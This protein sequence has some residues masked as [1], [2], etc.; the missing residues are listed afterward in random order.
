M[1]STNLFTRGAR[2]SLF[3]L[4]VLTC[5][6]LAPGSTLL[7]TSSSRQG[8]VALAATIGV[9]GGSI[10]RRAKRPPPS[11]SLPAIDTA[12]EAE[13]G[14]QPDHLPGP[15]RPADGPQEQQQQQ[16]GQPRIP[17]H[18]WL[19]RQT[20]KKNSKCPVNCTVYGTCN[21]ELG[22]CDCPRHRDG[23]NCGE[24]VKGAALQKRCTQQG[25]DDLKECLNR[26]QSC[27][28]GCNQRG[29]CVGGF[30]HCAP[31]FYGSE[32]ALS[33]GRGGDRVGRPVLLAGSGYRTREKRPWVYVYELPPRLTV[34][35]NFRRLDRALHL[36]VWQ[37]LLGSGARVA[38]GDVADYYFIPVQQRS[39]GGSGLG[40]EALD[41]VRLARPGWDRT[42]GH[43]HLVLHTG[44]WGLGEVAEDVRQTGV[45][46]TWLTY[47][48]LAVDR[49]NIYRWNL[50]FRPEK[51]VVIPVYISPGH[52]KHFGVI[53]SPLHPSAKPRPRN[54]S[55]LFFAGRICHNPKRPNPQTFPSCGDDTAEAYGAGIREKFFVSHWNRSGFHVVRSEPRYGHYMS[56]SQ[57]CLAPPGAGHGQRQIQALFMGCVPVSVADGVAEPFEPAL[58]WGQWG[59]RLAEA[60]IPRAHEI[61]DNISPQ[62]LA[63]KQSRMHCAAQHMLYSTITGAVLGEDGRYDAFETM[64]EVLRVRAAHPDA[65]QHTFRDL[66]PD[67]AAFMDCR[68]PPGFKWLNGTVER[69]T[70]RPKGGGGSGSNST[71][72]AV[73]VVG[74]SVGAAAALVGNAAAAN[75]GA[76]GSQQQQQQAQGGSGT[77]GGGGDGGAD[78]DGDGDGGGNWD[79]DGDGDG[80][81]ALSTDSNRGSNV[82][83]SAGP[84]V[85]ADAPGPGSGSSAVPVPA[86][87]AG[88]S[89]TSPGPGAGPG[90]GRVPGLCS[91]ASRD[92]RNRE[93]SCYDFLR[94][95]GYMG[96]P[97][98]AMCAKGFKT[99]LALCP[100]LWG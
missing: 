22:R 71:I 88:N 25:Y 86:A 32:C 5:I 13:A 73:S 26:N 100:R 61:L 46:M 58:D 20:A 72:K 44:D 37:R 7:T 69:R 60:D 19:R 80:A 98:G 75:P 84:G 12:A 24:L 65:P 52:F 49:P 6:I 29:Q 45:N 10:L 27:I 94:G 53:R 70:Q 51:D 35:C 63:E 56:R 83:A 79:G 40:R 47:W 48:G 92:M 50:A 33:L 38:D 67:F 64:L 34:W 68:P 23:P 39:Y 96:V 21:E 2:S 78:A 42:G 43:R 95:G 54:A 90:P 55:T 82:T 93:R 59:V 99:R 91:H 18:E 15:D 57:Y 77:Q 11:A 76:E 14:S 4:L 81:V 1:Y 66:D 36:Y 87:W 89:S 85:T 8:A 97:G 30:C 17:P 31:G 74:G 28:N 9:R 41:D 62:Q 3:G 16:Q